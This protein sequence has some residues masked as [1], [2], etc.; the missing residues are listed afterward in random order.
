MTQVNGTGA[1]PLLQIAITFAVWRRAFVLVASLTGCV[2]PGLEREMSETPGFLSLRFVQPR[3]H[4]KERC[5]DFG[6][7]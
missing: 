3:P 2:R 7:E 6:G 4:A 1:L 5:S